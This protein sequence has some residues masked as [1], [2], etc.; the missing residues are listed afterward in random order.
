MYFANFVTPVFKDDSSLKATQRNVTSLRNKLQTIQERLNKVRQ[1]NTDLQLEIFQLNKKIINPAQKQTKEQLEYITSDYNKMYG[2]IEL[3]EKLIKTYKKLEKS[4]NINNIPIQAPQ[5]QQ[6]SARPQTQ[7]GNLYNTHVI[8]TP[9]T[10]RT[11]TV[12]SPRKNTL[13][14]LNY[15]SDLKH[16]IDLL[17]MRFGTT[18][19]NEIFDSIQRRK[20]LKE[21]LKTLIKYLLLY[22]EHIEA[23]KQD[24]HNRGTKKEELLNE[25]KEKKLKLLELKLHQLDLQEFQ[26][27]LHSKV[28]KIYKKLAKKESSGNNLTDL[29]NLVDI[30]SSR[31]S[32][33]PRSDE[34]FTEEEEK[35]SPVDQK[36]V[37]FDAIPSLNLQQNSFV[38]GSRTIR[39]YVSALSTLRRDEES[40]EIDKEMSVLGRMVGH[41][42]VDRFSS[43]FVK[44]T[45]PI[46]K[47]EDPEFSYCDPPQD[48][49]DATENGFRTIL[50]KMEE[51][52]TS[53]KDILDLLIYNDTEIIKINKKS[54]SFISSRETLLSS[55]EKDIDTEEIFNFIKPIFDKDSIVACWITRDLVLYTNFCNSVS[56]LL[57][58]IEPIFENYHNKFEVDSSLQASWAALF[59]AMFEVTDS[60]DLSSKLISI[61][62][63]NFIIR[64]NVPI[65]KRDQSLYICLFSL[66]CYAPQSFLESLSVHNLS[67]S[68]MLRFL[69]QCG[70][71]ETNY[72][73]CF[74]FFSSALQMIDEESVSWHFSIFYHV[75]TKEISKE[76]INP[77]IIVS[78]LNVIRSIVEGRHRWT[79]DQINKLHLLKNILFNV[80][81]EAYPNGRIF[82]NKN[83]I[84][85]A[86]V[87]M[88]DIP[89]LS[90]QNVIPT[91]N[92][93]NPK[94]QLHF[95]NSQNDQ[96]NLEKQKSDNFNEEEY[97][98]KRRLRPVYCAD[99]VHVAVI[100]L[101]FSIIIEHRL[102]KFD[103]KFVDP[104]P[105]VNR[106]PNILYP[107]MKHMEHN[108]NSFLMEDFQEEF[109]APKSFGEPDTEENQIP[110]MTINLMSTFP[111]FSA[112]VE[113]NSSINVPSLHLQESQ[114]MTINSE[115]PNWLR[116]NRKNTIFNKLDY[117]RL[118]RLT[119]P[120][121]F[122]PKKYANGKHIASGAFGVVM[123]APGKDKPVAVKILQKSL[124]EFE[125]PH[126]FEVYSEVSILDTCKGDRRVTQLVDFGCTKNSYYIVMEFYPFTL[127][128]WRKSVNE[129]PPLNTM[130]RVYR[131]FL[132][133]CTVLTDR[134]INHFDIKC[135][136]V[137]LDFDGMPAL[138]DFG[139]SM[140]YKRES[141]SYTL[142]NKGTE[143]IKSPEMLSI[144]LTSTATDPKFDRRKKVGAG[145]PSD[146]WSIGCL[147]F[148]LLTGHFLFATTDWSYFYTRVTGERPVLDDVDRNELK[149]LGCN[150]NVEIFLDFVLKRKEIQRPSLEQVISKYDELFPEAKNA[151]TPTFNVS[152]T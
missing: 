99:D 91:L 42:F 93:D 55:F 40:S 118:L 136:N 84:I 105:H 130:L 97:L 20:T 83:K 134:Y 28:P 122:E 113:K 34:E 82:N 33:M 121:L 17:N 26:E 23:L 115:M 52:Y 88:K 18:I 39:R 144:A 11:K 43:S 75:L 67:T 132:K 139:E 149:E 90:L 104:F 96:N 109:K 71:F 103:V 143:W 129:K 107:L 27:N 87:S 41:I 138:A 125:N 2:K 45:K 70:D 124:N 32:Q 76:Q 58:I 106:K 46:T 98:S 102:H 63:E 61:V 133:A 50:E 21:D 25:L 148:E 30:A 16:N 110:L 47:V 151:P 112:S 111:K 100:E 38:P 120:C 3:T 147:F 72:N 135:D 48:V 1:K 4:I 51:L 80:E 131:E 142:L 116:S 6:N 7:L 13:P 146:I 95:Q 35:K 89:T 117:M 140:C 101:L 150:D 15:V 81:L 69:S 64:T 59:S 9:R 60:F 22:E 57:K 19:P 137:M 49:V 37:R 53:N 5:T 29:Q 123:K 85:K 10:T 126:L 77:I 78:T 108:L 79:V 12:L 86:D 92:F 73:V 36:N 31:I 24:I 141:N 128:A 152:N 56:N 68:M 54:A 8:Q 114:T 44:Y 14:N 145:P 62:G 127:K 119:M 66:G 74:R 65:Q 94:L